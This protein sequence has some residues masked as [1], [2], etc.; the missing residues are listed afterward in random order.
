MQSGARQHKGQSRRCC[1]LACACLPHRH[2]QVQQQ[3]PGRRSPHGE[4]PAGC[5][6]HNARGDEPQRVAL[7]HAADQRQV[8][9]PP[10]GRQRSARR[11]CSWAVLLS[12]TGLLLL[13]LL[14]LLPQADSAAASACTAVPAAAAPQRR[15]CC[16]LSLFHDGNLRACDVAA[17]WVTQLEARRVGHHLPAADGEAQ[18]HVHVS[19]SRVSACAPRRRAAGA[20]QHTAS[21]Q[22]TPHPVCVAVAAVLVK[23]QAIKRGRVKVE[24]RLLAGAQVQLQAGGRAAVG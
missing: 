9:A 20:T 10:G 4:P 6:V 12:S 1:Q 11:V 13:L 7:A 2:Q 24:R 3:R 23:V 21:Q 14:S 18:A 17:L 8:V 16:S 22:R 19:D 15:M 5:L